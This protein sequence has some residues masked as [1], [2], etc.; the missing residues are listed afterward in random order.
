MITRR[1]FIRVIVAG[2]VVP[3]L[4]LP[5]ASATPCLIPSRVV[6][7]FPWGNAAMR[8]TVSSDRSGEAFMAVFEGSG[9]TED[10][11]AAVRW[12]CNE[13]PL[14]KRIQTGITD[15]RN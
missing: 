7:D 4:S 3:L 15:G 12:V 9:E 2:T 14:P 11:R 8:Y 13:H 5:E 1:S 6:F 10:N